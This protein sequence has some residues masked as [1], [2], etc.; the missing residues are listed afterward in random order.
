M[1]TTAG[2][3]VPLEVWGPS[4]QTPDMGTEHAI[5]GFMMAYML[6]R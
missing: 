1:K 5:K 2:R 3:P 4:G 6:L